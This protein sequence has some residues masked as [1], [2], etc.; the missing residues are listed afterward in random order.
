[1][2][3]LGAVWSP[4]L[5]AATV[6]SIACTLRVAR[7]LRACAIVPATQPR[8]GSCRQNFLTYLSLYITRVS[9]AYFVTITG[10]IFL[11]E[12]NL[13]QSYLETIKV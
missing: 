8:A 4:A 10:N 5:V 7:H 13:V 2:H 12:K 9:H 3:E 6:A 1:M 11:L